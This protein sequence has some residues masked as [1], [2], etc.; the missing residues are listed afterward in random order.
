MFELFFQLNIIF[1]EKYCIE[2]FFKYKI[3][4]IE[5][6]NIQND[7]KIW[8]TGREKKSLDCIWNHLRKNGLTTGIQWILIW[9]KLEFVLLILLIW[10][11]LNSNIS[12]VKTDKNFWNQS[13]LIRNIFLVLLYLMK[14]ALNY[15]KVVHFLSI[16]SSNHLYIFPF[17]VGNFLAALVAVS[18]K[19]MGHTLNVML[20]CLT[21]G[22]KSRGYSSGKISQRGVFWPF[23]NLRGVFWL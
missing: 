10:A 20:I 4:L 22:E 11:V 16:F 9:L 13:N 5:S 3:I 12:N 17:L 6:D 23:S 7:N 19:T 21:S 1:R 15:L 18:A 2:I 14:W 8:F